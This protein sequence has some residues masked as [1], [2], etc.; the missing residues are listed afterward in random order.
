MLMVGFYY[1]NL[2]DNFF[3]D[4]F[5]YLNISQNA[6]EYGTWQFFPLINRPALLA[7]SPL[8]ILILTLSS[9]ISNFIGF[10][11]RNLLSAKITLLINGYL[12]FLIWLPFWRTN[13]KKFLFLGIIFFL[14]SLSLNTMIEFEG[15]LLFLWITTLLFNIKN[16]EFQQSNVSILLALGLFIRLDMTL[17]II[18]TTLLFLRDYKVIFGFLK[19]SAIMTVVWIGITIFYKVWPIPITYWAKSSL[20][21]LFEERHMIYYFFERLGIVTFKRIENLP[22]ISTFIGISI[23]FCL[24][25]VVL[26]GK[27]SKFI[28]IFSF[29]AYGIIFIKAPANYWWYYENTLVTIIGF[30]C[31]LAVMNLENTSKFILQEQKEVLYLIIL[32]IFITVGSAFRDGPKVWSFKEP[33]RAQGYI[34]LA[35]NFENGAIWINGIGYAFVKNP[36]IGITSYFAG[37]DGW[38]FD[39]GGLAQPL[40]VESVKNSLLKLLYP[41]RL[42]QNAFSDLQILY[43]LHGKELP[44]LTIWA[45]EDRD[46][47]KA[48]TKCKFVNIEGSLCINW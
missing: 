31:G 14:L 43:K 41:K 7:T 20:S 8:K 26:N 21:T 12:C 10:N 48:K 27:T 19:F 40:D 39:M 29:I 32:I 4:V 1:I 23:M 5:I 6:V 36:E 44:I 2:R 28:A 47:D 25:L 38:I 18:L 33:S 24:L 13:I 37:K 46:F 17:P 3:D 15:G 34:Y 30:I 11:E 22:E 16:R 9:H 42:R 45:L 35:N